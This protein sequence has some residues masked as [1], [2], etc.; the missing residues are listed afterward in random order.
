M[1]RRLLNIFT[2]LALLLCGATDR[3]EPPDRDER[4]R[5]FIKSAVAGTNVSTVVDFVVREGQGYLALRILGT[6]ALPHLYELLGDGDAR[7][8]ALHGILLLSDPSDRQSLAD[9]KQAAMRAESRDEWAE[10][11]CLEEVIAISA[12][13]PEARDARLDALERRFGADDAMSPERLSLLFPATQQWGLRRAQDRIRK[14]L[15]RPPADGAPPPEVDALMINLAA[16]ARVAH[17][18]PANRKVLADLLSQVGDIERKAGADTDTYVALAQYLAS[19]RDPKVLDRALETAGDDRR[20]GSR[21]Q[22]HSIEILGDAFFGREDL[23]P[24]MR[25][26][27]DARAPTAER[28]GA[29]RLLMYSASAEPAFLRLRKELAA[30]DDAE[31]RDAAK[32]AA[33]F[34]IDGPS[35]APG[36]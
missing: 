8:G 19:G 36:L 2:L 26:A 5:E 21:F 15:A 16:A 33:D 32:R 3:S 28:V 34:V 23:D 1:T 30:S 14:Y 6:K 31:V 22:Q 11:R 12:L 9:L 29:I 7:A 20:Y 27:A 24:L 4:R 13:G 35:K 10:L 25:R 18:E 17:I